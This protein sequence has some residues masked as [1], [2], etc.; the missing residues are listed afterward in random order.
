MLA[1]DVR[2]SCSGTREPWWR[3]WETE[4]TTVVIFGLHTSHVSRA[5]IL[6]I[7]LVGRQLVRP[8]YLLPIL[9]MA[10]ASPLPTF[11][12][13]PPSERLFMS[14]STSEEDGDVAV[15]RVYLSCTLSSSSLPRALFAFFPPLSSLP[16]ITS[17]QPQRNYNL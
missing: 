16:L 15:L 7:K 14:R 17:W 6:Y 13:C 5:P 12:I 2:A 9:A 1:C 3:V 4:V 8:L 11:T 10:M